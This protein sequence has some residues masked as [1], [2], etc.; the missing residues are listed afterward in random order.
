MTVTRL[1]TDI[2]HAPALG[3]ARRSRSRTCAL[4]ALV[5]LAAALS[6]GCASGGGPSAASGPLSA[7]GG[8]WV[9][10]TLASMSVREKVGQ[11]LMPFVLADYAPEGS[12][13]HDRV[14]RMIDSLAIGGLILSVGT[15]VDAAVKLNDFQRHA[16][17]PLLIGSDLET[18]AGFR[19]RGAVY[20]PNNIVLGGATEF[21]PLMAV[22]AAGSTELAHEM[23]RIT[24]LEARAVG[25]HVP[26]A[27]VLDV[28]SNPANPIIN[29]RSFGEDPERVAELGEALLRGIQENGAVATAKHFPGHGDTE[30]DSHLGL[31]VIGSDRARLDSVE[32]LPFRRAV[33]AG[34]GGI[35]TSRSE[36]SRGRRTFPPRCPRA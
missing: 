9:E 30:T 28:N 15:P 31:P 17:V 27:P 16:R 12:P 21:P 22:G 8:D 33:Q 6:G 36:P 32:L 13:G 29:T 26:F 25:V 7:A 18:G 3:G 23:G 4:P 1:R 11:M 5:L 24:A 10:R 35:M 20:S 2:L 34:V 19:F 14:V